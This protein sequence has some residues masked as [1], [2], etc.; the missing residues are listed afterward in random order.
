MLKDAFD[1]AETDA[2]FKP[3]ELG[4]LG[5]E[6]RQRLKIHASMQIL[7]LTVEL[8]EDLA[9]V[10][11]AYAKSRKNSNKRIPEYLRDFENADAFYKNAI[12]DVRFA[13]EACGYDP[14]ANVQ[15][16]IKVQSIFQRINE[17]RLKYKDWY[18][19]YK[20][21]QRTIPMAISSSGD[22]QKIHWGVYK[23]PRPFIEQSNQVFIQHSVLVSTEEVEEY[24][25]MAR[26]IIQLWID[27]R[28]IQFPKVFGHPP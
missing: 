19:S 15:D 17:F 1:K 26:G 16:A 28:S 5:D 11:S 22:P 9:A 24:I 6:R 18:N 20:H 25:T 10:C 2:T 13:A 14:I 7:S 8:T 3:S 27:V 4:A 21:G 12:N 23:I